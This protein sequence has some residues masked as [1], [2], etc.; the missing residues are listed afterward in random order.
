MSSEPITTQPMTADA[1]AVDPALAA[2]KGL[3]IAILIMVILG[4]G[5]ML[6]MQ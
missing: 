1:T 6:L 4:A 3:L 5:G 2:E